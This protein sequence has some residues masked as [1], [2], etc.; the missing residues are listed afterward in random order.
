MELAPEGNGYGFLYWYFR[1][2]RVKI[3]K[4]LSEE[5]G[6]TADNNLTT[7]GTLQKEYQT[8]GATVKVYDL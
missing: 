7:M 4:F 2:D 1:K 8:Y 3:S 5:F 6:I